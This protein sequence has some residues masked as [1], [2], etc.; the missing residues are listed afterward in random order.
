MDRSY[1]LTNCSL[2]F[3][4]ALNPK[5]T[6]DLRT[7]TLTNYHT[8][9]LRFFRHTCE[10]HRELLFQDLND[11]VLPSAKH[12][13]ESEGHYQSVLDQ[14]CFLCHRLSAE[15][16]GTWKSEKKSASHHKTRNQI[17]NPPYLEGERKFPWKLSNWSTES[18]HRLFIDPP[19][20]ILNSLRR[21]AWRNLTES[22]DKYL[23]MYSNTVLGTCTFLPRLGAIEASTAL[24]SKGA[25]FGLNASAE[26]KPASNRRINQIIPSC[27]ATQNIES[28]FPTIFP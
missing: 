28:Y 8:A 25:G 2:L 23:L 3:V 24:P 21:K 20:E 22:P 19:S 11:V 7:N 6:V 18:V 9:G 15:Y 12:N 14:K 5:S 26:V 13:Q 4:S 27:D 10:N 1:R 16:L 17:C